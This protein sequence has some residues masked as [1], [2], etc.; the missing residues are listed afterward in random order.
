MHIATHFFASWVFANAAKL[1]RRD[2]ALVTLSGVVPDLDGIGLI[3]ELATKNSGA[4]LYWWSDYHHALGHNIFFGLFICM[5]IAI[6]G[7][8]KLAAPLFAA[9]VFHFHLF[10]D[11]IGAGG[12]DGFNWPIYYFYPLTKHVQY[13]WSGQWALNAWPNILFTTLLLATTL[14]LSWREKYSPLELVSQKAD[15]KFVNV[16]EKWFGPHPQKRLKTSV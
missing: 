7:R 4:P 9:G 15:R 6:T 2:R 3:A 5:V 1:E 12:P 11:L 16:M 14:Y 10:C 8:R 13:A